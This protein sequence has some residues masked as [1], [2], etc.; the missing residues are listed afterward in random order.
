MENTDEI[1]GKMGRSVVYTTFGTKVH[2]Y[3]SCKK[4][5]CSKEANRSRSEICLTCRDFSAEEAKNARGATE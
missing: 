1:I 3:E 5:S 4:L 2:L